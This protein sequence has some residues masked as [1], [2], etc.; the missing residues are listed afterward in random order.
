MVDLRCG[1]P[2]GK[3]KD[4]P[5]APSANGKLALSRIAKGKC[6]W[7]Y[8]V[9]DTH[10]EEIRPAIA[11]DD[12]EQTW[13]ARGDV[14]L[15][16]QVADGDLERE[17]ITETEAAASIG[18]KRGQQETSQPTGY[19]EPGMKRT[20]KDDDEGEHK[21]GEMN[22]TDV[23]GAPDTTPVH[24]HRDKG[25]LA[26]EGI[27]VRDK[28]GRDPRLAGCSLHAIAAAVR[29]SMANRSAGREHPHGEGRWLVFNATSGRLVIAHLDAIDA[30]RTW[31]DGVVDGGL[32]CSHKSEM[33]PLPKRLRTVVA[34]ASTHDEQGRDN[35][36]LS[37]S[38]T[39]SAVRAGAAAASAA[40]ARPAASSSSGPLVRSRKELV[41]ALLA[42]Q[43]GDQARESQTLAQRRPRG[44]R[45][46][47]SRHPGTAGA[48]D[49]S[50]DGG[51]GSGADS[52]LAHCA[53]H[54]RAQ[55]LSV[56]AHGK[57]R[58]EEM[59]GQ[60][61]RGPPPSSSSRPA[62]CDGVTGR[63][64]RPR[65]RVVQPPR[66]ELGSSAGHLP[67]DASEVSASETGDTKRPPPWPSFQS[68]ATSPNKP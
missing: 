13:L 29:D 19:E 16:A 56:F 28:D 30:E 47:D 46:S 54:Q 55:G 43:H 20:K 1:G 42:G 7:A 50:T 59:G 4:C 10:H 62:S 18:Q 22:A 35:D 27:N 61:E 31:L 25:G 64:V 24:V 65:L 15:H 17:A 23:C 14:D 32:T 52:S 63:R 3:K 2:S 53:D 44:A 8:R 21:D 12:L 60:Q 26:A 34:D 6:P 45:T 36:P 57:D 38:V 41:A 33:G 11:W 51:E 68:S 67:Q 49:R 39:D 37:D 66:D 40:T 48:L 5:G 9:E 58:G